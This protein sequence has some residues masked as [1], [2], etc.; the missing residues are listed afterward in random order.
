MSN[1]V[2]YNMGP[3]LEAWQHDV[4]RYNSHFHVNLVNRLYIPRFSC[5]TYMYT[6]FGKQP[7]GTGFMRAGHLSY[8]VKA[9]KET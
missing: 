9:P 4:L 8:S 1:W 7:L 2:K 6:Y 3:L 5:S